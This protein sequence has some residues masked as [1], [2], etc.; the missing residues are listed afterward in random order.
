MLILKI[1]KEEENEK[2][3]GEKEKQ[4]SVVARVVEKQENA[5]KIAEEN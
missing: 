1:Y 2:L 4:R 3:V 5:R